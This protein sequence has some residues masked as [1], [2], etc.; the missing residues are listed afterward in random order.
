MQGS[1]VYGEWLGL[2]P[3]A[4]YEGRDLA[5]S[6]DFRTV[7]ACVIGRHLRVPDRSLTT[8]FPGFASP[9]SDIDRIIA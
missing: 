2:A 6:T 4:L 3:A 1:R 8:I 5:V 7:L 9:R